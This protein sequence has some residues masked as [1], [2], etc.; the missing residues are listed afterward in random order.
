MFCLSLFVKYDTKAKRLKIRQE[1]QK[2]KSFE[3]HLSLYRNYLNGYHSPS[4]QKFSVY[5][6]IMVM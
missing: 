4:K 3:L 2:K 6:I 1:E 5:T